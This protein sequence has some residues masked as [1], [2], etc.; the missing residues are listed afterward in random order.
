MPPPRLKKKI[1]L[2]E[3]GTKKGKEIPQKGE[4]MSQALQRRSSPLSDNLRAQEQWG[5]TVGD[6]SKE[7]NKEGRKKLTKKRRG[8]EDFR[9]SDADCS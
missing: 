1:L 7:T 3:E 9:E 5:T 4:K 8:Q 6:E 2:L